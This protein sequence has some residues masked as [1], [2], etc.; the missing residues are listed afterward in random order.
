MP[1]PF[2]LT[3]LKALSAALEEVTPANDYLHDLTASV[4][5]GRLLFTSHDPVPMV[6]ITEPPQMPEQMESPDGATESST[7]FPLLLQGFVDDDRENPTDPA[8]RLLADVQKRLALARSQGD[9]YDILGLGER[10]MAL[11]I[12]KGI[13][14]PPDEV[15]SKTAYFWLPVTLEIA[16]DYANPFA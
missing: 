8:Y 7:K 16:E 14:R 9:G 1:D 11:H 4:F 12:G 15:V 6:T 5:R 10:V 13:V 2:R 3:V